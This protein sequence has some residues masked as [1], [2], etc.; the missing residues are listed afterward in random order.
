MTDEERV[1]AVYSDARLQWGQNGVWSRCRV[2]L[3]HS[4]HKGKWVLSDWSASVEEPDRQERFAWA[5]A[6]KEIRSRK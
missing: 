2:V 5:E 1:K 3:A 4:S 6:A